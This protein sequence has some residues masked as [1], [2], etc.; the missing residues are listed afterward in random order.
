MRYLI[1][2]LALLFTHTAQARLGETPVECV[3]RYGQPVHKDTA[4]QLLLFHRAGFAIAASFHEGKCDTIGFTKLERN[5]IDIPEKI[6][7]AEVETLLNSNGSDQPWTPTKQEGLNLE[8]HRQD[9]AVIARYNTIDRL[10]MIA[11]TAALQR[12]SQAAAAK[13]KANLEGF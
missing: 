4:N 12:S 5:A 13:D 8:W 10:F 2:L 7:P 3:A 11:T 1:P 9:G 6:T